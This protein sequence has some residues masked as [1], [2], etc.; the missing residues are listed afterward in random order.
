MFLFIILDSVRFEKGEISF[1]FPQI[2]DIGGNKDVYKKRQ[3]I[4]SVAVFS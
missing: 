1:S 3:P 4:E 2:F